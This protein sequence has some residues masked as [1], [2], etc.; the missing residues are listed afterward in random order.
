[1]RSD[2]C[3]GEEIFMAKEREIKMP[4][5]GEGGVEVNVKCHLDIK[6]RQCECMH[7]WHI[8]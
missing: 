3:V 4:F 2:L 7:I 8:M 1:M 5:S 6:E